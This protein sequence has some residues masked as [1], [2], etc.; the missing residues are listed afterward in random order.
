MNDKRKRGSLAR[1]LAREFHEYVAD[2]RQLLASLQSVEGFVAMLLIAVI[3]VL[4]VGWFIFGLGFDRLLSAAVSLGASR[5]TACREASDAHA[6]ALVIGGVVFALV[7]LLAVGEMMRLIDR[8][9]RGA[10]AQ[11]GKVLWP[12]LVMLVLGLGGMAMMRAWC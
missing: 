7:A 5:P 8:V 2:F 12:A 11:A 6:V 10:Q 4:V 3:A 9:R 1:R